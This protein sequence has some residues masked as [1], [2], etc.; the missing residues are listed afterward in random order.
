MK[1]IVIVG[2][3]EWLVDSFLYF[4]ELGYEIIVLKKE[5]LVAFRPNYKILKNIGCK[6]INIKKYN[7]SKL[8][9]IINMD[10][11]TIFIRMSLLYYNT[12]FYDSCSFISEEL[13]LYTKLAQYNREK[14]Y[15]AKFVHYFTGDSCLSHKV[16]HELFCKVAPFIDITVFNNEEIRNYILNRVP[17]LKNTQQI[18]GH[19]VAP[20]QRYVKRRII[21]ENNATHKFLLLG[22]FVG[23]KEYLT[24]LNII[25]NPIRKVRHKILK[26]IFNLFFYKFKYYTTKKQFTLSGHNNFYHIL[27]S[28]KEFFDFNTAIFG[29]SNFYNALDD[30]SNINSDFLAEENISE[31]ITIDKETVPFYYRYTNVSAKDYSYLMFGIIPVIPKAYNSFYRELVNKKMAIEIEN[32]KD[33]DKVKNMPLSELQ[34]YCDNIYKNREI[35]CFEKT[36]NAIVNCVTKKL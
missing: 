3:G 14:N 9:K 32:I 27:A 16:V 8:I 17:V 18:I 11:E 4:K 25:D 36:A 12:N 13:N 31:F 23:R 28:R 15:N 5:A 33:F 1:K 24:D 29:L 21:S 6:I 10:H 22:R 7:F 19:I 30:K 26:R 20:L 34:Q 2:S 35:F